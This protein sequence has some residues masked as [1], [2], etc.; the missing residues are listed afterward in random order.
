L[1]V[2]SFFVPD[3]GVR[4]C[5]DAESQMVLDLHARGFTIRHHLSTV[6]KDDPG[7]VTGQINE[8]S[9]FEVKPGKKKKKRYAM[10]AQAV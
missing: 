4:M 9:F 2:V 5:G 3:A 10:L 8:V 1:F 7:A 6:H